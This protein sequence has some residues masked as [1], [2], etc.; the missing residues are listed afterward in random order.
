MAL[1]P[2]TPG[3]VGL[4]LESNSSIDSQTWTAV[5]L[6]L[7]FNAGAF[8]TTLAQADA[9]RPNVHHAVHPMDYLEAPQQRHLQC[10]QLSI[11]S[12]VAKIK[13]EAALWARSTRP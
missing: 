7:A 12:L 1:L 6:L 11:A 13:D 8:N 9:Q 5:G 10:A 4:L 2:A 3:N